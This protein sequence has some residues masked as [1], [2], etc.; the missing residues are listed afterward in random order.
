LIEQILPDLYRIEV[1]LPRNPLRTL[2][3]YLITSPWRNLLIDTGMNREECFKD[4]TESLAALGVDMARTDIFITHHHADHIGQVANL[5]HPSS[6]AYVNEREL[7]LIGNEESWQALFNS[8]RANGFPVEELTVAYNAH[9]AR[10]FQ[11]HAQVDFSFVRDGD[12]LEAGRY[13]FRCV[14]T[15]GHTPSHTCLYEPEKKILVG[16]D[17]ILFDITPNI[18]SFP[19]VAD[20]LGDYLASLD[21]TA[22][23]D[24][25]R[26]LTGHRSHSRDHRQ[27]IVELKEHH[28]HRCQEITAALA[29]GPKSAFEVAPYVHW[30]IKVENW[31]AFPPQ[32]KWFAVGETMTHLRYLELRGRIKRF[33]EGECILFALP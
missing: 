7:A 33:L 10:R 6:R 20:P 13:R 28:E 19:S 4:L 1:V 22:A 21:K 23:M 16:G 31:A 15:P 12:W 17:L 11:H 9:P 5:L 24:I 3:S 32:Q 26:V 25:D 2:N 30:D 8:Y 27:R 29:S 18:T 14:V